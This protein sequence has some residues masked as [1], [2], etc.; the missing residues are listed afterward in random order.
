MPQAPHRSM[1]SI[2]VLCATIDADGHERFLVVILAFCTGNCTEPCHY[3]AVRAGYAKEG[4]GRS[5][6]RIIDLKGESQCLL[7]GATVALS[8][9]GVVLGGL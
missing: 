9:L 5:C 2:Y 4:R 1:S 7:R 3:L 6:L 8:V